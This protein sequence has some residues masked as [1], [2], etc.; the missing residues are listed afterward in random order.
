MPKYTPFKEK[1]DEEVRLA[2]S[3]RI[4]NKYQDRIP[5]IVERCSK[6]KLPHNF[7]IHMSKL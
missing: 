5:I 4:L 7:V 1:Y 2:E 6:C 3:F